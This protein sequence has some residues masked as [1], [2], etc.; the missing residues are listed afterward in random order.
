MVPANKPDRQQLMMLPLN[1]V[2][3]IA[4]GVKAVVFVKQL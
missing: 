1:C 4:F 3:L 2:W